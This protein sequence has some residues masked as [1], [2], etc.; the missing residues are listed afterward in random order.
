[1]RSFRDHIYL[2]V[3]ESLLAFLNTPTSVRL[4]KIRDTVTEHTYSFLVLSQNK[5]SL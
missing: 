1:M 3:S 2:I 4:K 5:P